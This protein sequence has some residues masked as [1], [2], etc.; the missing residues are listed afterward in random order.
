MKLNNKKPQ[1]AQAVIQAIVEQ[2]VHMFFRV[3]MTGLLQEIDQEGVEVLHALRDFAV[4][5]V[6]VLVVFINASAALCKL[7]LYPVTRALRFMRM[8]REI[9]NN[10]ERFLVQTDA[11]A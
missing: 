7:L 5:F 8:R 3:R 4:A 6:N 10:P 1:T 9:M 2:P 11:E